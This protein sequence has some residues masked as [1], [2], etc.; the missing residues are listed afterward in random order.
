MAPFEVLA[1]GEMRWEERRS[2]E[3]GEE[4]HNY[5]QASGPTAQRS[6]CYGPEWTA[7]MAMDSASQWFHRVHCRVRGGQTSSLALA[8]HVAWREEQVGKPCV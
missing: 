5:E 6:C 8:R 2:V 1:G 4:D 7:C 3:H